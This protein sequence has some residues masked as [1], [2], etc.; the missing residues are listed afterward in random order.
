MTQTYSDTMTDTQLHTHHTQ[1]H[2]THTDTHHTH[3]HH[4]HTHT[5]HTHTHHTHTHTHI[6]HIN[7]CAAFFLPVKLLQECIQFH[8]PIRRVQ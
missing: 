2:I 7:L 1:T 6:T 3:T 4:T 5:S 8:W